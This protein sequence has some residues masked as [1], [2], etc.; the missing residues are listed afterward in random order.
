MGEEHAEEG[1]GAACGGGDG[2]G[3][4]VIRA[5]SEADAEIEDGN[6][7]VCG[8]E[9]VR[10]AIEKTAEHEKEGLEDLDI[11]LEIGGLL[12]GLGRGNQLEE[13]G[14]AAGDALPM[15]ETFL[16]EA[17]GNALG[18]QFAE[19]SQAADAETMEGVLE[20]RGGSEGGDGQRVQVAE[21]GDVEDGAGIASGEECEAGG[22]SD[23][24]L[25]DQLLM[26]KLAGESLGGREKCGG[27][28]AF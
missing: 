17:G 18:R 13:T 8:G 20:I 21:A 22:G 7:E 11:A 1:L 16:A 19:L 14:G 26:A 5:S 27:W 10:E 9:A 28:E 6:Y 24:D 3:A 15:E 4:G 2:E 12:E 23:A 25:C